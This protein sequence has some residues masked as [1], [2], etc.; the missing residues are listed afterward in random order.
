MPTPMVEKIRS[1]AVEILG[2]RREVTVLFLDIADFTATAHALDSEDIYLLTDE[3]MRLLAE[4]VYKYEGTIDKYTGDGLMALFGVPVAHENNQERAIRAAMEMQTVLQPLQKRIKKD[5]GFDFRARI[6]IN[7]GLVI[8]GQIGSDLHMEYTVIGD[9]VNL[10][11]RLQAAAELDTVLVSFAT[12]QRTR[13]FF[14]YKV[15]PL[16]RVK[17]KPHPLRT[18]RP[19]GLREKPERVR[20]LPGLQVPMVGRQD[21]LERLQHTLT[22][23]CQHRHSRVVL[24]TGE[25]GVGKSRLVA[26]F[27]EVVAQTDVSFFQGSCL[28]YARSKPLWLVANVVRDMMGLAETDPVEVQREVLQAYLDRLEL[29]HNDVLPYLNDVLALEQPDARIEVRLR[30]LDNAVLQK[31]THAALRRVFLAKARLAPIVLVFDDLHWVDPA[32]RDFLEH[33]IRS[34]DDVPLMIVLVSRDAERKTVIQP[35]IAAAEKRPDW[36]VDIQLGPLSQAE[37]QL[38]VDQL[39]K[40]TTYETQTL[41]RRI[42]ERAEGNPFYAEEIVRVLLEQGGLTGGNGVWQVTPQAKEL[43]EEVPGTLKGLILARFDRLTNSLRR[44]LQ[45]AAVLGSSFPVGLLQR[46]NGASPE[47]IVTQLSALEARQFL[48]ASSLGLEQGYMFRHALIQEVVYRTLLKRDRQ[49]IHKQAAQVIERGTFWLPDERTEAL[50]YHYAESADPSKALPHLVAAAENATRHCAHEI[51]IQHY[52]RALALM[53][54]QS[55]CPSEQFMRVQINLGQALKFVGA[56]AKARQTLEEALQCLLPM[57]LKVEPAVLLPILID[58]LRELADIRVREGALDEAVTHLEAGLNALGDEAARSHPRLWRLLVERLAW[59][60]FRQGKLE[61]GFTLASSATLGLASVGR[62]DPMTLA[63]LCNTLGGIFWKW[64]NL[65]EA[66]GYVGRSLELY[67]SLGYAWGMAVAYTNLGVLHYAQG[68]WSQAA[69]HFGRAYALRRENGYLPE[70]AV[71]LNNLGLLRMAMGDHDQAQKDLETSLTISQRLGDDYGVVYAQVGL[72]H[73]AVTQSRFKEAAAHIEVALGLPDATGEDQAIYARW[74]WALIQAKEGDLQAGLESAE[75]AL[76]M[77]RQTGLA[78]AEADCRRVLGLLR[79]RA[80]DYLEAEALLRESVDLC[81]QLKAPYGQ[82]LALLE[83]GHLYQGLARADDTARVEWRARA[84]T[85]LNQAAEQL[86][87]LGAAYDLERA[88]AALHQ[89]KADPSTS[90]SVLG[91]EDQGLRTGISPEASSRDRDASR[92]E[93]ASS[94]PSLRLPEGERRTAAIVWLTLSPPPGADEETVFET[95]A[96]VLPPLIAIAQEHQGRV[97]RRQ[98]GLMVVFGAPTAY[99]D[100]AERAVQ[101][102]WQVVQHLRESAHQTGVPLTFQVAV[103]QGDVVAGQIGSRLHTEFVVK[104]EPVQ[105]VQRLAESTP[106]GQ[107]WVTEAV[108]A[109]TER[110]F[111]YQAPSSPVAARL[112]DLPLLELVGLRE[113]PGPAR[114]L[115]G[116]KARLVGRETPLQAMTNLSHNLSQG[117]GGLIWIEGEPGIG[118]SR[119]MREFAASMVATDALTWAG[120]C[121]PQRASHAFSL[122]SDLLSQ[123]LNLQPTDTSDH[124]RARIDQTI[125]TWPKDAQVTRPYLE[126]LLGVQPGGL[127]GERLA[128]LTP[129]QLRQ[130]TFVALRRLFK[131]LASTQPMVV[132]LDDL[133]WIDPMSAE[134]LLF[135]LT[136]V[137]AVPILFVCAQRRQGADSPNDRLVRAQ[138]LIPSQTVR[139]CLERLSPPDSE[140]LLSELLSQAELPDA[141]RTTT[142]ERSEGNPYFIEEYLRMLVEQGY[143]QQRQGHWEAD[144]GL[145]SR[146]LPLP[147]SLKALIH[148]RVDALPPELKQLVQCAAVIGSPF[149]TSLLAS[150]SEESNVKV[151]LSRLVSRLLIRQG[152][153]ADRWEFNHSLIETVVYNTLLKARRR[154]L[155]LQVAQALEARWTGAE[156]DH[157]EALAYHFTQANEVAKATTYLVLAGERAAARFAN[158]EAK[159]YFEQAVQCMSMQPDVAHILRWRVAA[160]LGDVYRAMAE[161][162][163]SKATLQAALMLMDVWKLPNDLRAA[164]YR[165]LGETMHKQ[166]DMDAAHGHFRRAMDL[167]GEPIDRQSQTEAARIL[168]GL[169]W[170]HFLQGHFDQALQACAASVEQAQSADALSEL[171][172]AENLMGGIYYRQSD[173]TFALHHTMRAMVLRE[174]MGYSWGVAATLSNQG[175]LAVSAGQWN[176]ARSYFERSLAL[177]QEMG[178]VEGVAIVHNNLGTLTRDQGELDVAEFHFRESLAVARPFKMSFHI[179]NSSVGL[180]QVLLLKGGIEAAQGALTDGLAQ[181]EAIGAEDMLAE[182]HRI[183]AEI[184]LAKSAWDEA[185]VAAEQSASLA[186]EKGNRSLEAAAWRVVSEIGLGRQDPHAAREALVK[187]QHILADVTDELEAG[188]VAALAG[189]ISL[190]EGQVTQAEADLRVAQGVFMRLGASLDLKRVEGTP[191][192]PAKGY[193]GA[194]VPLAAD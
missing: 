87:G 73:L 15:L 128:R 20:G 162:G 187:A 50:A 51:A 32:S 92:A 58:G 43:V 84:L 78:E 115:P 192:Q 35:L 6:G 119:L 169:A 75:Q 90:P 143:L 181:A 61:E 45:K 19:L 104:G 62:D 82:G 160:G 69:E 144:L 107:V 4:V 68:M 133:H 99:E 49:K 166:G 25:A 188:R 72:A 98:D 142:L 23:V 164:L 186:A 83:L 180:A 86:E 17:G 175:I 54:D 55:T 105:V 184:L 80:G 88:R 52:R 159:T 37:A 60:R 120:R 165:R 130:Q 148:S 96:L 85:A 8:A 102:A 129:E 193:A 57:S 151:S 56:Y 2:E 89:L 112:A 21:A 70:Q 147:S 10:A 109:A 48:I 149:E 146:D 30:H 13:P 139:F 156:A 77:A 26:E 189:W 123:A 63:S 27:R 153:E 7:T 101:T 173:W 33:L 121:S 124:I 125:Q 93:V 40:G 132:L 154:E 97:I 131:S 14:D 28:T 91:P 31:L 44:T 122:F 34:I 168:T 127:N 95:M 46:L 138:G 65:V 1:T 39:V 172:T 161:Y 42:A 150:L 11:N 94:R 110:L 47:T 183:Q 113:E 74:L 178:D 12:Y 190:Y 117:F 177:R 194:L 136:M 163:N 158:E 145:H 134:L 76:Q 18:F 79:A 38:L 114:G 141:L 5:Y 71:S 126:M 9:T 176:K 185:K 29:A 22:Q 137:T 118:K 64:G 36:L 155:H 24:I 167:L 16:L 157:A 111:I 100:D 81:L 174:Q 59:V 103:S 108:R 53:Q 106:P 179:G 152:A 171:A 135:L 182:I 191:R 66:T 116:L 3:A 67:Q 170:V 41:K 140:T